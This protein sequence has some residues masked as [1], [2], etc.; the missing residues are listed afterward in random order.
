M[1]LVLIGTLF[2]KCPSCTFTI[3]FKPPSIKYR[4][5]DNAIHLSL[6]TRCTRSLK[7]TS[8]S[9]HPNIN[10]ADKATS[11]E[12]VVVLKE[13]DLTEE[14]R[15]LANLINLLDES[16]S[17]AICGVSLTG[18]EELYGMLWVVDDLGQTV[19]VGK[20]QVS[21][22]IGSEATAET[23]NQRIRID[24]LKQVEHA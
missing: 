23:D 22:L 14:L 4:E 16:L 10:T 3:A 18:E 8:W 2:G 11:Q 15:T 24:A 20:Q 21:A 5:V 6:F 12:E 9:I 13:D 19:E 7:R 17:C 1:T